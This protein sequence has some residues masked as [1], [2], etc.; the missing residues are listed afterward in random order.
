[1]KHEEQVLEKYRGMHVR[2]DYQ[3]VGY[4]ALDKYDGDFSVCCDDSEIVILFPDPE[5]DEMMETAIHLDN[6]TIT[7]IEIERLNPRCQDSY[8]R[9]ISNMVDDFLK[10][11]TSD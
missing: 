10:I 4:K 9:K 1:M 8:L 7:D 5:S 2:K 3:D 6:W 11:A